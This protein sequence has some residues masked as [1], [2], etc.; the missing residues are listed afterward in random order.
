MT[1]GRRLFAGGA[2]LLAGS[3]VANGA[4]Y[5]LNLL[6][7]RWLAPEAFAQVTVFVTAMLLGSLGA[8]ALQ[9]TV[10]AETVGSAGLAKFGPR[11]L[12]ALRQ[13]FIA[14]VLLAAACP[15]LAEVFHTGSTTPWL[16]LVAAAPP[17]LVLG[18]GRGVLQGR[19][20]FGALALTYVVEALVRWAVTVAMVLLGSEVLSSALGITSAIA[21]AALVA[22]H[23][24]RRPTPSQ[25]RDRRSGP[26][27]GSGRPRGLRLA[28]LG[29]TLGQAVSCNADVFLV[30][31]AFPG[32]VAGRYAAVALLGR[33]V[34]FGTSAVVATTFTMV[35]QARD[36][37]AATTRLVVMGAGCVAVLGLSGAAVLALA[38]RAT[39]ALLF[40][41]GFGPVAPLMAPYVAAMTAYAVANALLT[42]RLA[43]G[44]VRGGAVAVTAAVVQ[45]A[46][47]L[48]HHPSV[49]AVVAVQ[50]TLW[51]VLALGCV[52]WQGVSARRRPARVAG[53]EAALPRGP[54]GEGAVALPA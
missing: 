53:L 19:G 50:A 12:M 28:A 37:G 49:G 46:A 39:A 32:E 35:G 33:V 26:V 41:P 48:A 4:N 2:V 25:G 13:G 1:D 9:L 8:T 34:F 24:A 29:T 21:V 44:D 20:R 17:F 23:A 40:G 3:T 36:G 10:A 7:A 52:L 15:L 16:V 31:H 43:V 47:L 5:A 22:S 11:A 27:R 54:D 45:V 14:F 51:G 38:P 30:T 42:C 6:L 18:V